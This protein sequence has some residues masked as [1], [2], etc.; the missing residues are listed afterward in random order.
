MPL[1]PALVRQRLVGL[2]EFKTSLVYRAS[3]RTGSKATQ[4]NPVLKSKTKQQQQQSSLSLLKVI[5]GLPVIKECWGEQGRE[6]KLT[7]IQILSAL[8][9]SY[10]PEGY[11]LVPSPTER[12]RALLTARFPG[13]RGT[14]KALT[15]E[16]SLLPS[17]PLPEGD[18]PHS[19]T[20]AGC[21]R[22][23]RPSVYDC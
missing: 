14:V 13:S 23:W 3:D 1:I 10:G 15:P 17:G 9:S 16:P 2:C 19:C 21:Q 8:F 7:L 22:P 20:L 5:R 4:R 18:C 6:A 12:S 11:A